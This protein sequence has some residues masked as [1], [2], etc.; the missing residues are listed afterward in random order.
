MQSGQIAGTVQ[1]IGVG[2]Q[3]EAEGKGKVFQ[4]FGNFVSKFYTHVIFAR[5]DMIAKNPDVV[6]RFLK[7]W[8]KTVAYMKSHKAET[9]KSA[10]A[11]LHEPESVVSR[12]YDDDMP[13]L[14]SNGAWDPASIEAVRK[15]LNELGI[16]DTEPP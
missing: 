3:L 11:V 2:Y 8:F 14:S 4:T 7:G 15:S 12:L 13:G 6:P 16:S 10:A 9:V 5:D 1:D